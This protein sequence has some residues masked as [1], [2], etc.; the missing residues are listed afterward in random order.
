MIEPF[1]KKMGNFLGS[2]RMILR[3]RQARLIA[4]RRLPSSQPLSPPDSS[5]LLFFHSFVR[6]FIRKQHRLSCIEDTHNLF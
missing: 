2:G 1:Q 5:I 6:D 4:D 3:Q